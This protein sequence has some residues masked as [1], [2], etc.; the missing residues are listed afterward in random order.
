MVQ[1]VAYMLVGRQ[2]DLLPSAYKPA[3][4]WA[5]KKK[6]REGEKIPLIDSASNIATD[7]WLANLWHGLGL[8]LADRVAWNRGIGRRQRRGATRL[9]AA[10]WKRKPFFSE[11]LQDSWWCVCFRRDSKGNSFCYPP[12]YSSRDLFKLR[13]SKRVV[14]LRCADKK[15]K[16]RERASEEKYVGGAGFLHTFNSYSWK[17]GESRC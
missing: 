12:L 13:T 14:A 1:S 17:P 3:I 6:N 4:L 5:C 15:K 9:A 10:N 2:Q 8:P 16:W 11:S 7:C